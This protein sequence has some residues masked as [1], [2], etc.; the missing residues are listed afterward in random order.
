MMISGAYNEGQT[1]KINS[2]T[3]QYLRLINDMLTDNI[4]NGNTIFLESVK[5]FICK[6]NKI[7]PNQISAINRI[8]MSKSE[9]RG[10]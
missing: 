2:K 1:S 9:K 6:Y 7:T 10:Q 3:Q 5:A 4:F 8:Y